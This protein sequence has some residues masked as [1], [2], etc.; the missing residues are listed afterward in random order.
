[1]AVRHAIVKV[2]VASHVSG[3]VLG[4]NITVGLRRPRIIES[5]VFHEEKLLASKVRQV[6]PGPV[7]KRFSSPFIV[8][9]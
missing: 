4:V 5:V 8:P 6:V 7:T 3:T 2:I 1:M 9:H